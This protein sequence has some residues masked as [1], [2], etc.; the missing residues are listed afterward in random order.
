[1]PKPQ[2]TRIPTRIPPGT[3]LVIITAVSRIPISASKAPIPVDQKVPSAK[4]ALN[5]YR[6]TRVGPATTSL[7][8][9][10]PIKVI[11]RPIPLVTPNFSAGGIELKTLR[12]P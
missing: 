11:N 3:F 6:P 9:C 12:A 7:E 2:V 5:G 4:A 10:K 8:F 1:M